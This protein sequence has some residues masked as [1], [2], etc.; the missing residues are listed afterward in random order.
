[1]TAYIMARKSQL[2]GDIGDP[3]AAVDMAEAASNLA[4]PGSRLQALAPTYACH[5][6]ALQHEDDAARRELDRAHELLLQATSDQAS[7][8][9]VWLDEPYL[10]AQRARSYAELGRF[11]EAVEGFRQAIAAVPPSFRRDL[12]VYLSRESLAHARAGEPEQAADVA[13]SALYIAE[14]TGSARIMNA[15]LALD[16][17]LEPWRTTPLVAELH[18]ALRSTVVKQA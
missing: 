7:P 8:W 4:R 2:A 5:G 11:S 3:V 6:H 9:A 1:M 12:G 18:S 15:L 17:Q 14:E 10:Q 13:M 16:E